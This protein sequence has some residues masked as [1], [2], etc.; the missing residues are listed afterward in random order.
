MLNRLIATL[1]LD[2]TSLSRVAGI[3]EKD[4]VLAG[5]VLRMVNSALYGRLG[6]VHTVRHAVSLL[7]M[8]RLRNV[9]MGLASFRAWNNVPVAAGWSMR[10]FNRHSVSVAILADLIAQRGKLPCAESA[11]TAGIFHDAGRLLIAAGLRREHAE[12]EWLRKESGRPRDECER[13]V[14][15]WTHA[16]LSADALAEWKLPDPIRAAVRYHHDPDSD[17]D[18]GNGLCLSRILWAADHYVNASGD[19]AG[20]RSVLEM[21]GLQQERTRILESFRAELSAIRSF[22]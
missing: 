17:P 3:I 5:N 1:S 6:R 2:E 12:I 21:L 16:D 8:E 4:P 19:D 14:V 13:Q 11:F 20:L 7:G 9:T 22:F 15:G 18:S 10:E